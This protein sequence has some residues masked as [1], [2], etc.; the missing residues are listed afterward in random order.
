MVQPPKKNVKFAGPLTG[1][2]YQDPYQVNHH[3]RGDSGPLTGTFWCRAC[4]KLIDI[5]QSHDLCQG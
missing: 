4:R 5:G 1:S 3:T 2:F